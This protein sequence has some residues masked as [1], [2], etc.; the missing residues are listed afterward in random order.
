M[1]VTSVS[2]EAT[3]EC[4]YTNESRPADNSPATIPPRYGHSMVLESNTNN[5][6]IFGGQREERYLSDMY[7]YDLTTNTAT[8]LFSDFTAAGGPNACFTQRAMIDS[9]SKE[10]YV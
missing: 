5:L 10:I 7:T 4:I 3:T 6:Y 1:E 8:E 9:D 2:P